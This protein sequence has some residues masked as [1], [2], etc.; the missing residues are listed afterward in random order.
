MTAGTSLVE[1]MSRQAAKGTFDPVTGK[2]LDKVLQAVLGN[3]R[4]LLVQLTVKDAHNDEVLY[5]ADMV[6]ARYR[7]P[8]HIDHTIGD[9]SF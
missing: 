5:S 3:G 2:G 1:E 8:V 7:D 6:S 4:S 9:I